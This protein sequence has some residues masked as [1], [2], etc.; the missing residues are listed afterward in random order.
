MSLRVS[1]NHPAGKVI[2]PVTQLDDRAR[3]AA[4]RQTGTTATDQR[5]LA[6]HGYAGES[7]YS[8][9]ADKFTDPTQTESVQPLRVLLGSDL[10]PVIAKHAAKRL[11]I[12]L[13]R[14]GMIRSTRWEHI[15]ASP[16]Y[17]CSCGG[18]VELKTTDTFQLRRHADGE[19]PR[20][21]DGYVLP[22]A[23]HVQGAHQILASGRDHVHFAA[24]IGRDDLTCWTAEYSQQELD[25]CWLRADSFW[26]YVRTRTPPLV[27]FARAT[28]QEM[29]A[30]Y[31]IAEGI[32]TLTDQELAQFRVLLRS[33]QQLKAVAKANKA[34]LDEI[35]AMV[36]DVIGDAEEVWDGEAALGRPLVR[37]AQVT[38]RTL[39]AEALLADHPEVDPS[40]YYRESTYRS[41]TKVAKL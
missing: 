16:D 30:R 7:I 40:P 32:T 14:A 26:E 1:S 22:P 28:A 36:K 39:D 25:A 29:A 21:A 15:I 9:W 12:R 35:E 37:Y 5:V 20:N 41:F 31:P 34:S 27:D 19:G 2:L 4:L 17:N 38:K 11:G 18:F 24:L 33:R 6:G 8:H 13:A 10:E 3:W 23:W